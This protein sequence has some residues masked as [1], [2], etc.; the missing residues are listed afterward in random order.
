MHA[1][2]VA[3]HA[4]VGRGVCF[5][6]SVELVPRSPLTQH[7]CTRFQFSQKSSK[8]NSTS[9]ES[10][11]SECRSLLPELES[12][13][14]QADVPC[15]LQAGPGDALQS[16]CLGDRLVDAMGHSTTPLCVILAA[17]RSLLLVP[18][19]GLR[20]RT[21]HVTAVLKVGR[22]F[23]WRQVEGRLGVCPS[24]CCCV[25]VYASGPACAS[26]DRV[27]VH[28]RSGQHR[29]CLVSP[30]PLCRSVRQ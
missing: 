6:V 4:T 22:G 3:A 29:S 19:D 10:T 2:R 17:C 1:W 25:G 24:C 13:S 20:Q 16:D 21:D 27:H 28:V 9:L 30:H 23:V 26:L 8:S 14:K 15:S 7:V 18:A 11:P 5:G 12:V